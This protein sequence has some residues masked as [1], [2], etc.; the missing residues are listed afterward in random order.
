MRFLR[1]VIVPP[2]MIAALPPVIAAPLSVAPVVAR[3]INPMANPPT[4]LPTAPIRLFSR[5]GSPITPTSAATLGRTALQTTNTAK[6]LSISPVASAARAGALVAGG[7]SIVG[8]PLLAGILAATSAV[9]GGAALA[10]SNGDNNPSS[11]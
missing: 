1:L 3:R 7:N 9:A 4:C 5:I 6:C 10:S 11:P 8:L 2:L